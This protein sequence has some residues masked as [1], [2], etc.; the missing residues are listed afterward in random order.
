[1]YANIVREP[2]GERS[3]TGP[4]FV[5]I[6]NVVLIGPPAGVTL[7]GLNAQLAPTSKLPQLKLTGWLKPVFGVT[8]KNPALPG[9]AFVNQ[10]GIGLRFAM[11]CH[12][13]PLFRAGHPG[14]SS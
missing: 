11:G 6:V 7:A 9:G 12:S 5:L 8:V 14:R 4:P 3:A 10:K 13:S 1:M 2:L